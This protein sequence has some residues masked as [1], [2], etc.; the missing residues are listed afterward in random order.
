VTKG[1]FEVVAVRGGS[2]CRRPAIHF[3]SAD[4]CNRDAGIALAAMKAGGGQRDES[5]RGE[6]EEAMMT[7]AAMLPREGGRWGDRDNDD[8]EEEVVEVRW[9]TMTRPSRHREVAAGKRAGLRSPQEGRRMGAVTMKSAKTCGGNYDGGG[10]VV[11]RM[12][13]VGRSR[14]R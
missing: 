1:G 6:E 4:H 2:H 7:V 3:S 13:A 12:Q 14:R 11:L 10:N 8:G 5:G 9:T